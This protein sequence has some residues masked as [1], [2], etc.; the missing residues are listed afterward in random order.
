MTGALVPQMNND[1]QLSLPHGNQA[2]I[3]QSELQG[4]MQTQG[5]LEKR[6]HL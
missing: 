2:F 4:Q 5:A 1:R 3:V 6:L